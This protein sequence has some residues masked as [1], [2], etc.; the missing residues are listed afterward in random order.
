MGGLRDYLAMGYRIATQLICN[1][2]PG[3]VLMT[4]YQ[5]FEEPLRCGAIPL[6]L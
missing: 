3:L 4:I 6:G 1:D 5:P 2:F